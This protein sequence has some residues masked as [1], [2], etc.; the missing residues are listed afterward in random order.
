MVIEEAETPPNFPFTVKVAVAALAPALTLKV[1]DDVVPA[2]ILCR[3]GTVSSS[4][5]LA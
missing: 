2:T 3:K 5:L 4:L 1:V